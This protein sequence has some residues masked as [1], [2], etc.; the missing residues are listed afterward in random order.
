[1]TE[2]VVI[3]GN[4]GIVMLLLVAAGAHNDIRALCT[5]C[6]SGI[7]TIAMTTFELTQI[8]IVRKQF[9]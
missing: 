4:D 6:G 3:L 5:L 8:I 9:K 1:M 7:M 2:H